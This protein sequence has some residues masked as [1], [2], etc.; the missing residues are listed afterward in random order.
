MYT[1]MYIS[2][3]IIHA[4]S[5]IMENFQLFLLILATLVLHNYFTDYIFAKMVMVAISSKIII[6][7]QRGQG[8]KRF[9]EKK[10]LN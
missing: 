5:G 6:I 10:C 9:S 2:S 4:N 1:H 3:S 7:T 8:E